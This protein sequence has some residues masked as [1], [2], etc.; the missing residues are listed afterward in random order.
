MSE[1][2]QFMPPFARDVIA[3][4]HSSIQG[5][6]D[7]VRFEILFMPEDA[8]GI[9]LS[10]NTANPEIIASVLLELADAIRSETEK[11]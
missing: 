4:R 9:T 6:I 3:G 7:G 10:I 11:K 2:N 8:P 5:T 1:N